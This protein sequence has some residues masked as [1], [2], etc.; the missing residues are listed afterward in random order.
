MSSHVWKVTGATI[1]ARG[2]REFTATISTGSLDRENDRLDPNGWRLDAFRANPVVLWAHAVSTPPIGRATDVRVRGGALVATFE[3]PPPTLY[4]LA[5]QV[6][7]LLRA[8]FLT[9]V[10]VGFRPIKW[11]ANERG[12]LDYSEQELL[13]FSIVPVPANPEAL[14]VGR[15]SAAY[16]QWWKGAPGG[17]A[18]PDDTIFSLSEIADALEAVR[19]E[20]GGRRAVSAARSTT[21][22]PRGSACPNTAQSESCPAGRDCPISGAVQSSLVFDDR[23]LVGAMRAV[24]EERVEPALRRHLRQLTGRLD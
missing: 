2:G 3:F 7:G 8:G 21:E 19:R 16:D 10:S 13:E 5:D 11:R 22:C 20:A 4:P 18:I 15:A 9:A 6:E 1:E 17:V 23:D 14:L 24:V 12:G